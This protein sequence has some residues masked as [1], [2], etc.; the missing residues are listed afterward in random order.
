MEAALCKMVLEP[1]ASAH[2]GWVG[3]LAAVGEHLIQYSD[4]S[5]LIMVKLS[6]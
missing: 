4:F 5:H 3:T 2:G 6:T 1:A